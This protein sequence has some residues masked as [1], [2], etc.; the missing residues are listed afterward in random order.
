MVDVTEFAR[1]G[2]VLA[3]KTLYLAFP[4]LLAGIFHTVVIRYD[5]LKW[6]KAP[7]D[8]GAEFRGRRILG[9][10]KTWR[11]AAAMIGMSSL[12]M[13]AQQHLRLR[14]LE[15]FD[16]GRINA[17][18][19]GSLLGLGFVAGELPNSFLKRQCGIPPGAQATGGRYW[20]VT[21]FDQLD[22]VV[23][24]LAALVFVWRPSFAVVFMTLL[25]GSLFHI[26]FNLLFVRVGIKQRAF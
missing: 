19:G 25:L 18:L 12:G 13:A 9:A 7:M 22:S 17:M 16:Y 15:L 8:R 10:N 21:V 11:G 14:E 24:C 20:I 2:L 4:V 26:A 3:A 6:L 23:G 5:L 1:G